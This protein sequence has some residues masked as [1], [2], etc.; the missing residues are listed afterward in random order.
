MDT[1]KKF[2][3]RLEKAFKEEASCLVC[4]QKDEAILGLRGNREYTGANPEA[5]P[6]IFTNIVECRKCGFIY[7]NPQI[8]GIDFLETEHYNNPERYEFDDA[9]DDRSQMY[10]HRVNF[11]KKFVAQGSLLDI[12]AGS[13]D[14]VA[15][16]VQNGFQAVGVEPTPRSCE[17]AEEKFGVKVYNGVLES[18]AELKGKKFDVITLFHVFEHVEQPHEL[19][20]N[21]KLFLNDG[22]IIYIEVPN[23]QSLTA[24]LIDVYF[25]LRGKNWSGR[26]S[27]MHPP[28]HKFGYNVKSLN[29]I[30]K[31]HD[32]KVVEVD[33]FSAF[34]RAFN[35]NA[36]TKKFLSFMRATVIK[37]VDTLGNRDMLAFVAKK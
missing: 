31:A 23:T 15:V 22:G 3:S 35:K 24:K 33:T 19:L 8:K 30:L 11:I 28:F 16:A 6:H 36:Q 37:T 4:G 20:E 25:R 5:A 34:S 2:D 27:P 32:F 18:C 14:F 1:H 13:G 7:T 26:L 29:F 10:L 17:F 21:L 9:E 12:G